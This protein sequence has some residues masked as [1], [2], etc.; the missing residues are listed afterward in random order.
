MSIH[1]LPEQDMKELLNIRKKGSSKNHADKKQTNDLDVET[2]DNDKSFR[3]YYKDDEMAVYVKGT[4]NFETRLKAMTESNET[5]KGGNK[6]DE[7][8]RFIVLEDN[9]INDVN[10]YN[11]VTYSNGVNDVFDHKDNEMNEDA[12]R[13]DAFNTVA[14]STDEG[15]EERVNTASGDQSYYVVFAEP[16]ENS[17]K[18]VEQIQSEVIVKEEIQNL[19]DDGTERIVLILNED[20][21]GKNFMLEN[22]EQLQILSNNMEF[23]T[24]ENVQVDNEYEVVATDPLTVV[25]DLNCQKPILAQEECVVE[26][27][28]KTDPVVTGT[29]SVIDSSNLPLLEQFQSRDFVSDIEKLTNVPDRSNILERKENSQN[30][31]VLPVLS[32]KVRRTEVLDVQCQSSSDT[33]ESDFAEEK[34]TFAQSGD[35]ADPQTSMTAD[36]NEKKNLF[37]F[38]S[39]DLEEILPKNNSAEEF[40]NFENALKLKSE[41]FQSQDEYI[42]FIDKMIKTLQKAKHAEND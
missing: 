16:N 24:A 10:N 1:R 8:V 32:D 39:H 18:I 33:K 6:V 26:A 13:Q 15:M 5:D 35:T 37:E 30:S 40:T 25:E 19:P 31:I 23:L 12:H 22:G 29:G 27:S 9:A 2:V 21:D 28:S 11:E 4:D 34:Y 41:A 36:I 7:A 38:E 17:E 20:D 14:S 3:V 42:K